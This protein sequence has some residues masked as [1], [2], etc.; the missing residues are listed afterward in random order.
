[1]WE[2]KFQERSSKNR[3]IHKVNVMVITKVERLMLPNILQSEQ[4]LH[5]WNPCQIA[6]PSIPVLWIL[7]HSFLRYEGSKVGNHARFCRNSQSLGGGHIS[8]TTGPIGLKFW[9]WCCGFPNNMY[10]KFHSNLRR[11]GLNFLLFWVIWHGMTH[12]KL[13]T[14]ANSANTSDRELAWLRKECSI[15]YRSSE[16]DE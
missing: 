13:Q 11:S 6:C 14:A 15:L 9:I 10:T 7:G 12:Y 1:M 8:H 3:V 16:T 5:I 4:V 2:I